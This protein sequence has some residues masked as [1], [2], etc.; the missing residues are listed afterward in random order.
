[1]N[2]I[3]TKINEKNLIEAIDK[4]E[5]KLCKAYLVMSNETSKIFESKFYSLR[6]GGACTGGIFKQYRCSKVFED[7]SLPFGEVKIL[8]EVE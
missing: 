7:N 6:G 8:M 4:I 5:D 2:V 1:M 3:E